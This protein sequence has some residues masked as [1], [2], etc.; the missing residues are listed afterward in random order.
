MRKLIL[1]LAI[2]CLPGGCAEGD[3]EA[4]RGYKG[5]PVELQTQGRE[6]IPI[7]IKAEDKEPIPVKV[8]WQE[9]EGR[10][11]KVEVKSDKVLPVKLELQDQKAFP[12]KMELSQV[13]FVFIA[14][15]GAVILIIVVVTC[16]AVIRTACSVKA[17]SQSVD[18]IKKVQQQREAGRLSGE[19]G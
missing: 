8:Q 13:A 10:T 17:V 12:V 14:T 5:F 1:C 9:G 4:G 18:A 7:K 16:I 2:I 6:P 3:K 11:V 19:N 15:F